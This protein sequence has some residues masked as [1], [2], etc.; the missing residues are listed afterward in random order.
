MITRKIP[1][2]GIFASGALILVNLVSVASAQTN[3]LNLLTNS[4]LKNQG[5]CI[6]MVPQLA[7]GVLGLPE[8]Q[9]KDL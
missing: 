1:K 4:N 9:I 2:Y 7:S 8:E 6:A 5:Q 3:V